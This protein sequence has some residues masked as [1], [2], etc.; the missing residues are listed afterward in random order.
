MNNILCRNIDEDSIPGSNGVDNIL[1][2]TLDDRND[3]L[4]GNNEDDLLGNNLVD[5]CMGS[6]H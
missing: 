2:S 3:D 5:G 6:Q 4:L 1:G